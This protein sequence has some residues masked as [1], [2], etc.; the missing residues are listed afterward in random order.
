[1]RHPRIWLHVLLALVGFLAAS[2]ASAQGYPSKTIRIVSP[3]AP[4]GAVDAIARLLC[5]AFTRNLGQPCVVE[6]RAGAGGAIGAEYAAKQA[7]DG[8]TLLVGSAGIMAI[9]PS[10]GRKL[11]Y[12]ASRDFT[13]IGRAVNVFTY[14]GVNNTVAART[15]GELLA[16]AKDKPGSIQYASSGIGTY[17]HLAGEMLTLASGAP[18]V[19]VPYKGFGPAVIDLRAGHVPAM[20]AGEL[21]ELGKSG[22]VRLLAVTN[23][24]RSPDFPDVPTLKELGFPQFVTH[25]WIGLFA[26]RGLDPAIAARLSAVIAQ[27]LADPEARVKLRAMGLEPA[28]LEPSDF[29]R[30]IEADRSTYAEIIRK[31]GVKFD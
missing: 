5:D 14:I 4:G 9:L 10:S 7:A 2:G 21:A 15:L 1:M 3:F 23:E 29:S 11:G 18:L 17:A 25:S 19:H 22:A 26:P 8:Y 31:A 28:H 12:D 16:A 30:K 24:T 27:A 13:S 6:T 20:I